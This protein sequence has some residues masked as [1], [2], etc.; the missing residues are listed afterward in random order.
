MQS[1]EKKG[2]HFQT[3]FKVCKNVQFVQK[4]KEVQLQIEE[5]DG[6]QQILYWP[7]QAGQ[8]RLHSKIKNFGQLFSMAWLFRRKKEKICVSEISGKEQY[9]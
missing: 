1:G 5:M 2:K 9:M 4:C 7:K 8:V 3:F 6:E